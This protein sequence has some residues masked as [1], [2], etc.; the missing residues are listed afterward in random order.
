MIMREYIYFCNSF[1][2]YVE[3]ILDNFVH[4]PKPPFLYNCI[5]YLSIVKEINDMM[6]SVT[7]GI[8]KMPVFSRLWQKRKKAKF[9]TCNIPL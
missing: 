7:I 8:S 6:S 2:W 9:F 1:D 4:L 5:N 3:N